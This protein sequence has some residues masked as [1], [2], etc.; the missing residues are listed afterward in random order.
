MYQIP[1]YMIYWFPLLQ[2]QISH[3]LV[4]GWAWKK[5]EL[6]QVCK[7]CLIIKYLMIYRQTYVLQITFSSL[8]KQNPC[9]IKALQKKHELLDCHRFDK[10]KTSGLFIKLDC[11]L[12]S[13]YITYIKQNW[14]NLVKYSNCLKHAP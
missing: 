7:Y 11:T 2:R 9:L 1:K 14:S 13:V 5:K 6:T 12:A 8:K 10:L 3:F 4:K